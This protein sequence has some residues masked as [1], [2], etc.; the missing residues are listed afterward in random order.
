[1]TDVAGRTA[2]IT[3]GANGI[4]LGIARVFASAGA[5]LALVDIDSEAL[6]RAKAELS[7]NTEVETLVLD[8]VRKHLASM[9]EAKHSTTIADRDLIERHVDSIGL[10]AQNSARSTDIS[11]ARILGLNHRLFET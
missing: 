6:N 7:A 10:S 5:K 1:M 8:G 3:G 9:D 11:A 2:F 4:G